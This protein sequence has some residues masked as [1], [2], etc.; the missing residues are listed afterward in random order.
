MALNIKQSFLRVWSVR[1]N[2]FHDQLLL[3]CSSDSR[4]VLNSIPSLSS[5]PFNLPDDDELVDG[6]PE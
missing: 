3:T 4:V 5:E 2:A 6:T 1:Y